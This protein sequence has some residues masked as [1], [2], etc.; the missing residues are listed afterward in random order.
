MY[1]QEYEELD[2]VIRAHKRAL[3][4]FGE[5][6]CSNMLEK[7]LWLIVGNMASA[8]WPITRVERLCKKQV[9]SLTK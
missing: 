8:T 6:V 5:F 1:W 3:R 7:K 9:A 2:I 4:E